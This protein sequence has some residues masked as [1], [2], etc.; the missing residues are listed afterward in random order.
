MEM[1]SFIDK[2]HDASLVAVHFDWQ[3]RTCS[4]SF[5]GAPHPRALH[6]RIQRRY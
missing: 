1:T 5:S 4:L 2:L 3:A 6:G